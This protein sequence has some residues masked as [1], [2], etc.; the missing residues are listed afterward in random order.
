MADEPI[1]SFNEQ[2]RRLNKGRS[3]SV[4]ERYDLT[5]IPAEGVTENLARIRRTIN[6]QV[7]RIRDQ[8][9]SNFRVESAAALTNDKDAILAT[10][11][12]TRI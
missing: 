4:T 5:K 8:H 2:L 10:V 6:A 9:G 11:A 1:P 12:V 7:S 3:L